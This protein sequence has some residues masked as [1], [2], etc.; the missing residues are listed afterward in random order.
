MK[1]H[2]SMSAI[3]DTQKTEAT[4]MCLFLIFHQQIW[5]TSRQGTH[6]VTFEDFVCVQ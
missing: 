4:G 1:L 2:L 5:T 6:I 3:K